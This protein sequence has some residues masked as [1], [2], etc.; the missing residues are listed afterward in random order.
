M[1]RAELDFLPDR[2]R[3]MA[4]GGRRKSELE[5]PTSL[6]VR[7]WLCPA[8]CPYISRISLLEAYERIALLFWRLSS[9][10]VSILSPAPPDTILLRPLSSW[11]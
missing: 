2:E 3:S 9:V 11:L 8:P 10:L 7:G 6:G 1:L 4:A 5:N